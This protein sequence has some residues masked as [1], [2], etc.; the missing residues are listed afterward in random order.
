MAPEASRPLMCADKATP[1]PRRRRW[2][3]ARRATGAASG[4]FQPDSRSTMS[5][6]SARPFERIAWPP[7][8][9]SPGDE[10][11]APA[12]RERVDAE[13][14]G[15]LVELRFGGEGHLRHAEA[16]E[17]AEAQLVG[18]GD[19][20]VRAH[21]RDAV[22]AALH[23]QGVAE[24][25][26]AVVAVGAAVEQQLDLAG[27]ERAVAPGAGLDADGERMARP[28]RLEV[29]L[30]REDQLARCAAPSSPAARPPAGRALP[31]CCRSRR[32]RAASGSAAGSSAGRATRRRW[33]GRGTPTGSPTTSVMRPPASISASAP[34][35]L[36]REVGLRLRLEG[37]LDDGVALAPRRRRRRRS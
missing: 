24:D 10:H 8:H 35:R 21:V 23:Q 30:A 27:D 37:R 28:H 14:R 32:R 5:R 6:H 18:V 11:V 25:A 19:A 2:P 34:H 17:G 7:N 20:A 12:Q 1:R 26:G 33:P 22:G 3:A 16:A 15:E 13:L 31:S 9:G 4:V 29:F 36:E